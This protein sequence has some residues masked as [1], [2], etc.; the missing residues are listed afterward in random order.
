MS[1]APSVAWR[2]SCL[3][4]ISK[5]PCVQSPANSLLKLWTSQR[6]A[7]SSSEVLR[8]KPQSW[9]P[10]YQLTSSAFTPLSSSRTTTFT[11]FARFANTAAKRKTQIEHGVPLDSQPLSVSEITS[12]FGPTNITPE[13]GNRILSVLQGRRLAGTLDMNLPSDITREV[14][15]KTIENGLQWLR[16]NHP[17]DEDAAIM[18]RI[19]REDK[20]EEERLVQY[21]KG[22]GPQSGQW[23]AQ[24]GEGDDIYGKSVLKEVR[25]EN[26]ARL[27]AEQE[28]ERKEWLE[29]EAKDQE[30]YRK[31]LKKNTALQEYTPAE[32]VKGE[33]S[34]TLGQEPY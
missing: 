6:L 17:M 33:S 8:Y 10:Q 9:K 11:R 27:L 18:A 30:K 29:G 7:Y 23:G 19:E 1:N 14:R 24:L 26:E 28:K 20:E 5:P 13:M 12:I 25:K 21:V 3:L 22:L 31:H 2:G 16:K 4:G 15:A 34:F 32:V